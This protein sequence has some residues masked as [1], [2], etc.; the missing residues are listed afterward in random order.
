MEDVHVV[1]EADLCILFVG[2]SDVRGRERSNNI[3]GLW[4]GAVVLN[5]LG[6]RF[7]AWGDIDVGIFKAKSLQ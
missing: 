5:I 7:G 4:I 1:T 6:L 3:L 2:Q